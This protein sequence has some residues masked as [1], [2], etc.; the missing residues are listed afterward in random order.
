MFALHAT[1]LCNAA[2][3]V[4]LTTTSAKPVGMSNFG[5]INSTFS[6]ARCSPRVPSFHLQVSKI[7]I[8]L[9]S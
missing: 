1:G 7:F 9:N 5:R 8:N 6:L 3:T 2:L 4:V